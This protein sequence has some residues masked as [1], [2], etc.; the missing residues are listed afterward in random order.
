MAGESGSEPLN[1]AIRLARDC[2]GRECDGQIVVTLA[3]FSTN[4]FSRC[5]RCHKTVVYRG[6]VE[7]NTQDLQLPTIDGIECRGWTVIPLALS[8]TADR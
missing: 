6:N 3:Q 8:L 1:S 2:W 7:S 5:P 4:H